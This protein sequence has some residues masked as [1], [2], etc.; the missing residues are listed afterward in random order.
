MKVWWRCPLGP[1]HEWCATIKSRVG[2]LARGCP[3][4]SGHRP[5]VTNS[6]AVVSPKLVGEWDEERNGALTPA[7]VVAGSARKCWWRCPAGH[8]WE[9]Q[10]RMR[11]TGH[12][13]P[14]C[15]GQ[16]VSAT[17]NIAA[18]Y[19]EVA[20]EWDA[21]KNAP[22]SPSKIVAG[23]RKK[24]WWLCAA[25][26]SWEASV[27]SRT[28]LGA[29][30]PAC[31]LERLRGRPRTRRGRTREDREEH[32]GEPDGVGGSTAVVTDPAALLAAA[33]TGSVTGPSNRAAVSRHRSQRM[34]GNS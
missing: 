10:V 11:V 17:N 1:D 14:F 25:G 8:S 18:G 24:Y 21:A 12:G 5:S 28:R 34:R 30:C 20:A 6:L 26:H 22:A 2:P 9:A 16:R 27:A 29:G 13:C 4:C 19:P 7:G 33:D 31:A 32:A 3:F 23:S 15:A